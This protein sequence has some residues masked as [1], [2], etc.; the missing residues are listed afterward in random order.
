MADLNPLEWAVRPLKHYADFNGRASRA[1]YWWFYLLTVVVG[2]PLRLIDEALDTRHI[3]TII[4]DL[5][6]FLPWLAV[7]ARRLH[8]TNRSG[9]WMLVYVAVFAVIGVLVAGAFS[10]SAVGSTSLVVGGLLALAA[11]AV[12]L[13]FM[14]LPGTEGPNRYGPDPYGPNDL[15][16]VFA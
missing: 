4:A 9:G 11:V 15:E 1:E 16:E 8:D 13:V 14:I 7:T 12:F 3:L 10:I 6:L 5:G 2:I